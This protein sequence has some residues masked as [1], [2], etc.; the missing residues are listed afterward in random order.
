MDF[1]KVLQ[2]PHTGMHFRLTVVITCLNG[3][4]LWWRIAKCTFQHSGAQCLKN[5]KVMAS[6]H[7]I[8]S[9]CPLKTKHNGLKNIDRVDKK[10][11]DTYTLWLQELS[12]HTIELTVHSLLQMLMPVEI[13][14][15]SSWFSQQSVSGFYTLHASALCNF[16]WPSCCGSQNASTV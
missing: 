3:L 2:V 4:L 10:H 12:T 9:K 13:W 11:W 5:V 14:N 8:H 16:T 6:Q 15:T 1:L 7:S